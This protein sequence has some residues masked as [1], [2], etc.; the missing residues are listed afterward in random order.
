MFNKA[1]DKAFGDINMS[2]KFKLSDSATLKIQALLEAR[3]GF[4]S[5]L[6]TGVDVLQN[7]GPSAGSAVFPGSFNPLHR[8]HLALAAAAAKIT[9]QPVVFEMS[10]AQSRSSVE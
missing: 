9:E 4:R 5:L 2:A 8:G 6:F 10:S 7:I 3:A 1:G